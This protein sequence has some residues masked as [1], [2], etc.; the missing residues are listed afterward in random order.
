MKR[1]IYALLGGLLAVEAAAVIPSDIKVIE[2]QKVSADAV[3][4]LLQKAEDP[5]YSEEVLV[6]ILLSFPFEYRQYVI[7]ALHKMK[8]VSEKTRTMPGIIEW[9]GKLPTRIAPELEEYAKEWLPYLHPAFYPALM[10]EA[11]PSFHEKKESETEIAAVPRT[12]S[13]S[14]EEDMAALFP[15]LTFPDKLA[16]RHI[17]PRQPRLNADGGLTDGEIQSTLRV[18]NKIKSLGEGTEGQKRWNDLIMLLTPDKVVQALATPCASLVERLPQ[19]GAGEWLDMQLEQENLTRQQYATL[20]DR[21]INAYRVSRL[22]PTMA[23]QIRNMQIEAYLLPPAETYKKSLWLALGQGVKTKPGD[24]YALAP[25]EAE[26]EDA[27][28]NPRFLI[29]GTPVL[30]DF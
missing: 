7:P 18:F 12:Y 9:R 6:Q 30:L 11:W 28:L 14:S 16:D 19:I 17:A 24:V 23:R 8:S 22:S 15:V 4:G 25:Y 26:L 10:P 29:M 5:R 3:M 27:F 2:S 21:V 13:I 20:C 1:I